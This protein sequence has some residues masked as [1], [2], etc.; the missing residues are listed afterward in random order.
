MMNYE[1]LI[2]KEAHK[3]SP[4]WDGLDSMA[5]TEVAT[6]AG[7]LGEIYYQTA[8]APSLGLYRILENAAKNIPVVVETRKRMESLCAEV[9]DAKYGVDYGREWVSG[10]SS[11]E[12]F[13]TMADTASS[14]LERLR[15]VSGSQDS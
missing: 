2:H 13:E 10:V 11:I 1:T 8:Q 4:Y 15:S 9:V 6:L 3:S 12:A 14:L 5:M 7:E